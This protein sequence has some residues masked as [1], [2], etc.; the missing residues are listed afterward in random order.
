[1]KNVHQQSL[2]GNIYLVVGRCP[3][4]TFLLFSSAFC[5]CFSES[6]KC[7]SRHPDQTGGADLTTPSQRW[8]LWHN[9]A[10][11]SSQTQIM[12]GRSLCGRNMQ[13]CG[14]VLCGVWV[15][16][17]EYVL[18]A[19]EEGGVIS[20]NPN[21]VKEKCCDCVRRKKPPVF[22]CCEFDVCVLPAV[23]CGVFSRAT[24]LVNFTCD[25][26]SQILL[27]ASYGSSWFT[28]FICFLVVYTFHSHK[29]WEKTFPSN[30]S[31]RT[32][33]LLCHIETVWN[34]QAV[35]VLVCYCEQCL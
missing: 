25:A 16:G 24:R 33:S 2:L 6:R 7:S 27:A 14:E 4:L 9:G 19:S 32:V 30:T 13:T 26:T 35:C 18:C 12:L 11:E 34:L 17:C 20:C 31:H 10:F 3:A 22:V 1:M 5:C 23:C 29:P 8:E 21:I 28:V 15:C